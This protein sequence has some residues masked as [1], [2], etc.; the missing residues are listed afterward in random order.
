VWRYTNNPGTKRG[1]SRSVAFGSARSH[2][3]TNHC[4]VPLAIAIAIAVAVAGSDE[5]RGNC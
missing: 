5:Q 4:S 1:S 3:G 2:R